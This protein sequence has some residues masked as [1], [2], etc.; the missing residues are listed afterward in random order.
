MAGAVIDS[1]SPAR[2]PEFSEASISF[3][4]V[5]RVWNF[6]DKQ[7]V[8]H[9]LIGPEARFRMEGIVAPYAMSETGI[10]VGRPD[11]VVSSP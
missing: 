5:P 4:Q 10:P 9:G 3:H 1:Q 6:P 11:R 8:R 2:C 7:M